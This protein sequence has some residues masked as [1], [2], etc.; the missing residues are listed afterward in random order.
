MAATSPPLST[1]IPRSTPTC[2]DCG[3]PL[4]A[5][6]TYRSNINS[7]HEQTHCEDC[8]RFKAN[9]QAFVHVVQRRFTFEWGTSR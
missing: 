9:R 2:A 3:V 5:A 1:R 4:T 8:S 6:K 7:S